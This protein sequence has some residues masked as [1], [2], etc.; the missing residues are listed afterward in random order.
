MVVVTQKPN[1]SQMF[2]GETITLTCEVQGGESTEWTY[3][4]R[5]SGSVIHSTPSKDWTFIVSESSS[6]KYTCQCRSRDDWYSSTEW[7][8]SII[9]SVSDKPRAT[10]TAGPTVIPLGGHVILSCSVQTSAGWKYR[11][12]R[13][14]SDTSEVQIGRNK[15]ESKEITVRQGGIYRCEG[16]RGNPDFY[17]HSSNDGTINITFSNKVVVTQKPNCSQMFSGETIT[18][19]C[20]VQGGES[21]EWTYEWRRSGS[22]IHSTPSKD[23]TF[24]VSESSSGKYTCQC[25]SRDDWYSSTEWSESII[26]SVSGPSSSPYNPLFPVLLIVGSVSGIIVII[27][28]ALLWRSRHPNDRCCISDHFSL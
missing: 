3:E 24:N 19:T 25:R 16:V 10:L 5:R 20:E 6:G 27:I 14:T 13:R 28:L 15:K 1:S 7:S 21:T 22:V 4:W 12:F 26:L 2:S 9:L 18:L 8:E 17:T 11:W 23:W